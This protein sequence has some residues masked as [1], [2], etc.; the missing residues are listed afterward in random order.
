MIA[1]ILRA[2]FRRIDA[3]VDRMVAAALTD[4]TTALA[5]AAGVLRQVDP[6]SAADL[7]A[8]LQAPLPA[9][10]FDLD[11]TTPEHDALAATFARIDAAVADWAAEVEALADVEL[12]EM[13]ERGGDV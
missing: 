8:A 7:L 11:A 13:V 5:E 4:D 9:D 1:H 12:A 6:V 2:I 3:R 10:L